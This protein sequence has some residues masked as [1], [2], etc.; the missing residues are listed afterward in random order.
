MNFDGVI[1]VYSAG[2]FLA[3]VYIGKICVWPDPWTDKW[4]AG[5]PVFWDPIWR[6]KWTPLPG[7]PVG[8][9]ENS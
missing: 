4:D 3:R 7:P 5:N 1:R 2:V 9:E 6:D 8:E